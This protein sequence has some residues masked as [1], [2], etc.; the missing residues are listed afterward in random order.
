MAARLRKNHQDEIRAKI[1][2]SQLINRLENHIFGDVELSAS[3]VRGIEIL[4][5]KTLPNLQ[6][7]EITGDVENPVV[8][9]IKLV[10]LTK[11][12]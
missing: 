6:A 5:S 2:T 4:L 12:A 7:T 1:K 10:P 11:D 3:Q 9:T 8:H